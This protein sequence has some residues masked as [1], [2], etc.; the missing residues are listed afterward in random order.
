MRLVHS[1]SDASTDMARSAPA[2]YRNGTFESCLSDNQLFPGVYVEGGVTRTYTQPPESLG[3]ISTMPYT[4]AIPSSSQCTTYSSAQ[5]FAALGSAPAP[6]SSA[7]TSSAGILPTGVS[8]VSRGV[9]GANAAAQ[10][11]VKPNAASGKYVLSAGSALLALA[12]GVVAL[13]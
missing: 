13:L 7:A 6:S 5:I 4:A 3:V 10:T 9:A 12:V 2:A 1:S 8:T 11:S